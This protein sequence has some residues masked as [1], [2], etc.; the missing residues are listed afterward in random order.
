[1]EPTVTISY[2]EYKRMLKTQ[3]CY[4]EIMQGLS[5]EY[6]IFK[7]ETLENHPFENIKIKVLNKYFFFGDTEAA[8]KEFK[9]QLDQLLT[10]KQ[11]YINNRADLSELK[12]EATKKDSKINELQAKLDRL[13]KFL[14][15]LID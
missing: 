11:N 13:P 10:E 6:P 3:A 4:N 8:K 9:D 5:N 2:L 14:K 15:S 1:M 12:R 7:R